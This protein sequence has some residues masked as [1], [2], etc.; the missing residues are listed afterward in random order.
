MAKRLDDDVDENWLEENPFDD[1][2][3]DEEDIASQ[4]RY[5]LRRQ[6]EFRS[7]AE[8][9]ARALSQ[10]PDVQRVVLFGS[11]AAP[12]KKKVPRFR[13]YRRR[14]IEVWHEC[15]DADLAVWV[16]HLD[17]LKALQKARAQALNDLFLT[18]NV[19]VAHHQ[20]DV[21]LMEPGADRYLGRLCC[22]GTCP[23]GKEECHVPGCGTKPFLKQQKRFQFRKDALHGSP[24]FTL[25]ERLS[26]KEPQARRSEPGS[27]MLS[28]SIGWAG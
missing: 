25:Y 10:L 9:V 7:A 20:V 15:K 5:L 18:K 17:H 14:G 23:K 12:L 1:S 27:P 13:E 16:N 3:P 6:E 26:V 24:T 8:F 2:T 11:V 28:H 22:F 21:F 19:G 4:D